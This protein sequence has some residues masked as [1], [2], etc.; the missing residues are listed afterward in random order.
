MLVEVL[1]SAAAWLETHPL[2]TY[3]VPDDML[4]TVRAGQLVAIPYGER[5]VEG[6]IWNI[7]E[8]VS[9]EDWQQLEPGEPLR[10][11]YTILDEEPALFPYQMTLAQWISDYYVT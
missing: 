2:L 10:P 8:H 11:L 3:S 4:P 6:I 9:P 7:V 5:L 1:T